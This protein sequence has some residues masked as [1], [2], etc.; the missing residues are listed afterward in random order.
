MPQPSPYFAL[1]RPIIV[2]NEQNETDSRGV[3]PFRFVISCFNW[4]SSVHLLISYNNSSF[5]RIYETQ[6]TQSG[7]KEVKQPYNTSITQDSDK[8]RVIKLGATVCSLTPPL[9]IN[10]LF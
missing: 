6:D 2:N 9:S 5:K 10:A 8:L 7:K 4:Q 3:A 1:S